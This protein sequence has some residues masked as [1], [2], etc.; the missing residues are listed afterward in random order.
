[1][2]WLLVAAALRLARQRPRLLRRPRAS[3]A[4]LNSSRAAQPT[5]GDWPLGPHHWPAHYT[6]FAPYNVV[7]FCGGSPGHTKWG[8]VGAQCAQ[9]AVT[10]ATCT[11]VCLGSNSLGGFGDCMAKCGAGPPDCA[12]LCDEV[13]AN[14]AHEPNAQAFCHEFCG[15]TASCGCYEPANIPTGFDFHTCMDTCVY[16]CATSLEAELFLGFKF[17]W[18]ATKCNHVFYAC[19]G[20]DGLQCVVIN[21][22]LCEGPVGV[23]IETC[24][25]DDPWCS[26]PE[27][28]CAKPGTNATVPLPAI[29]EQAPQDDGWYT[30]YYPT[31]PPPNI[32]KPNSTNASAF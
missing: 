13:P 11:Q 24:Y 5:A 3:A 6:E 7:D 27:W 19:G 23:G 4:Q 12:V 16:P 2:R 8:D 29:V 17:P 32:T 20:D 30:L 22:V 15:R 14:G 28:V 21:P 25:G 18:R 26:D 1:M 10:A 31:P 9:Y